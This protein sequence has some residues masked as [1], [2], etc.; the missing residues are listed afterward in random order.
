MQ[1]S[2]L[3]KSV[4]RHMVPQLGVQGMNIVVES[5]FDF[6]S[7]STCVTKFL[8]YMLYQGRIC[9]AFTICVLEYPFST[10]YSV[11]LE[12]VLLPRS[13]VSH[14]AS[15]VSILLFFHVISW[16]S[17]TGPTDAR[18]AR[19]AEVDG[20]DIVMGFTTYIPSTNCI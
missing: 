4:V 15:T 10:L 6:M 17:M 19:V 18:M 20:H 3:Q 9:P 13:V 16:K 7:R 14:Y 11:L 5:I 8:I 2:R 12:A 1:L